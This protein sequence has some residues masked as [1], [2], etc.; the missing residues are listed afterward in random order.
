MDRSKLLVALEVLAIACLG[1]SMLVEGLDLARAVAGL[2]LWEYAVSPFNWLD[3]SGFTIQCLAWAKWYE[4]LGR[5]ADLRLEGDGDYEVLADPFGRIRPFRTNA[6]EEL[7]LLRLIDGASALADLHVQYSSLTGIV[8]VVLTFKVVK[9]LDF[10]PRMG[11]IT[12]TL[13]RTGGNLAHFTA[14]FLL[15]FFSYAF[16]GHIMF[17]QNLPAMSTFPGALRSLGYILLNF[18][19]T[20]FHAQMRHAVQRGDDGGAS[21]EYEVRKNTFL[22]HNYVRAFHLSDFAGI[23]VDLRL[24][25]CFHPPQHPPCYSGRRLHGNCRELLRCW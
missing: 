15:I 5:A 9:S 2:S 14:L 6:T 25:M 24:C 8:V 23:R 10:Q 1:V 22:P 12:R 11:L 21:V 7:A 18:D 20:Q 19:P 3:L 13:A 17:G 4:I 16:V